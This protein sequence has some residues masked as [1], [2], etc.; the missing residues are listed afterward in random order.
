MNYSRVTANIL[1][2]GCSKKKKNAV[3]FTIGSVANEA[4]TEPRSSSTGPLLLQWEDE[5]TR[6]SVAMTQFII[7]SVLSYDAELLF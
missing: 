6:L 2:V 5:V 7:L 4:D 1:E 3:L